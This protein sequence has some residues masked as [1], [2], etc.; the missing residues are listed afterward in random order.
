MACDFIPIELDHK[1][2]S[3]ILC[4]F[5]LLHHCPQTEG[6]LIT[7]ITQLRDSREFD[8]ISEVLFRLRVITQHFRIID[9][10]VGIRKTMLIKR[11]NISSNLK[12]I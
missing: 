2:P 12:I 3:F 4:V 8:Q 5:C 9:I 10:R 6:N 11:T 1:H 7:L